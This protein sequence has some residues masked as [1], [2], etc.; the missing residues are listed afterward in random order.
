M[1]TQ[2]GR[3]GALV[4][5]GLL[6]P[7]GFFFLTTALQ[8]DAEATTAAVALW[9][10]S[11]SAW[12]FSVGFGIAASLRSDP[13]HMEPVVGS[14]FGMLVPGFIGWIAVGSLPAFAAQPFWRV[15]VTLV[16]AAV[17]AAVWSVVMS[18]AGGR[19]AERL[20]IQRPGDPLP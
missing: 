19:I 2:S 17:G 11:V 3:F 15:L 8:P 1:S 6:Q 18:Y 10:I 16:G 7:A 5:G 12:F 4:A 14:S 13:L 9:A 20:F